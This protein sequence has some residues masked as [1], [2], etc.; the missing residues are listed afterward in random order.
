MFKA[1]RHEYDVQFDLSQNTWVVVRVPELIADKF[2]TRADAIA[3]L[4]AYETPAGAE[5]GKARGR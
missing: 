1:E 3:W 5:P 4:E 2:A